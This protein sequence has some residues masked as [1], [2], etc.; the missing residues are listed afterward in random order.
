MARMRRRLLLLAVSPEP[1]EVG[2]QVLDFLRIAP[3]RKG[4]ARAGGLL[5]RSADVPLE[6]ALIPG[7]AGA[8]HGVRIVVALERAGL[9]AFDPVERRSELDLRV[10]PGVVAGQAPFAESRVS[11][12]H[13]APRRS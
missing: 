3:A 8:L 2:P 13:R 1:L 10:G 5:H 7:D 6:H 4:H 12:C 9:A 11:L